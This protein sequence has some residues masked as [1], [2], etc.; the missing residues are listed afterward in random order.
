[1]SL[2]QQL[3]GYLQAIAAG[4]G[5]NRFTIAESKAFL[6]IAHHARLSLP[7]GFALQDKKCHWPFSRTRKIRIGPG[8]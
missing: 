5:V 1:L 8:E 2:S 7:C 6:Y 4:H 3:T